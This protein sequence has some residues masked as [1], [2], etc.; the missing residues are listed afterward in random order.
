MKYIINMNKYYVPEICLRDVRNKSNI[1]NNL[2]DKFN[3]Q[4]FE[5]NMILASNGYYKYDKEKLIKY[6]IIEKETFIVDKFLTKYSLIG[7]DCYHKKVGEVFSIPFENTFVTIKK[8]K[9]NVGESKNYLVFELYNDKINDL[10]F[11]SPKK[12][13]EKCKFFSNDISSFM[14]MLMYK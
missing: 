14:E 13:N 1:I 6:K 11:L 10:Y 5:D 9:F 8:I 4:E 7:I 3:K 2:E 12:I